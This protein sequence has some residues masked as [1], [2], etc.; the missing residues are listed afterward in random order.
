MRAEETATPFSSV[1]TMRAA[2]ID[3][4]AAAQSK[5]T[6]RKRT[7]MPGRGYSISNARKHMRTKR[8]SLVESFPGRARGL[9]V[10]KSLK[11]SGKM[12]LPA[13]RT[14]DASS[15]LAASTPPRRGICHYRRLHSNLRCRRHVSD[16]GENV[17]DS[18][19][20]RFS[21]GSVSGQG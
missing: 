10:F 13:P 18:Q 15:Q 5:A 16:S 11:L 4:A 19:P 20:R 7:R 1:T 3:W 9:R 6:V 21:P 12:P 8:N 14:S 2:G 17:G